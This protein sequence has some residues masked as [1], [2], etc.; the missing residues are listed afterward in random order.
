MSPLSPAE[1]LKKLPRTRPSRFID[2]IL[3]VD[4]DHIVAKYTWTEE[5]CAGHFPGNPVVPGVKMLEMAAQTAIACWGC[6]L[7]GGTKGPQDSFFTETERVSFRMSVRPG[8]TVVCRA[9]FGVNGS[10]REGHLSAEIE[11]QF[12]GG[13]KDGEVILAGRIS[14]LWVL[15]NS[16]DLS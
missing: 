4:A 14:G 11:L 8:E 7:D 2:E 3:V 9:R 10:F 1:I 5:D 12:L 6:Y 13:P 15:Q 16:E